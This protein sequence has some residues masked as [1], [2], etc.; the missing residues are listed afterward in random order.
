MTGLLLVGGE[1]PVLLTCASTVEH[2]GFLVN[3]RRSASER[4]KRWWEKIFRLEYDEN[5]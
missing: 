1:R 4:L 5:M 2:T 3:D